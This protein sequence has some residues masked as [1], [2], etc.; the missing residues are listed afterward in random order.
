[1]VLADC[2]RNRRK[3]EKVQVLEPEVL[4]A[5]QRITF[6]ALLKLLNYDQVTDMYTSALPVMF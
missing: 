5:Q 3:Y 1:M 4:V 6:E 2:Q